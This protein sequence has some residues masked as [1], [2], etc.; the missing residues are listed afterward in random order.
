MD[1]GLKDEFEG[2]GVHRLG[3]VCGG[4][5]FI[6]IGFGVVH[7]SGFR[8]QLLSLE[9]GEQ[10]MLLRDGKDPVILFAYYAGC[11]QDILIESYIVRTGDEGQGLCR[12]C[13]EIHRV[14]RDPPVHAWDEVASIGWVAAPGKK[15]LYT[16][17][18]LRFPY[19]KTKKIFS[20]STT[21]TPGLGNLC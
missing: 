11:L 15:F 3:F 6:S 9:C 13:V 14:R 8:L 18:R 2:L 12:R 5:R 10:P 1:Q 20:S 16:A 19:D 21:Q 17:Q 7:A 4:S